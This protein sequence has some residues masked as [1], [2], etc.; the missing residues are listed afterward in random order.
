MEFDLAP[1]WIHL[2]TFYLVS[3]PR[4]VRE[5]VERYRRALDANPL[6]IEELFDSAHADDNLATRSKVALAAYL[7]GRRE[8]IALTP[9]TTTGLALLYNGLRIRPDQEILTTEH[10]HYVHHES[11]RYAAER[12]G[13]AVRF[14]AL[15]DFPAGAARASVA[16]MVE[17]L[18]R[19]ISPKTRA[20]GLTWVHSATGLKLPIP[21]LAEVVARANSG[22]ADAD[23]CLLIV[24]GVH[25]F[26]VENVDA[27][28]LGADF[29]VASAHKWLFAPRGTGLIWGRE[30]AW[31]E[32][33]PTIPNFDP[34]GGR[35]FD[36]WLE[37]SA[38]PPTRAA[39]VS[40]GGFTAYEHQ[41][42]IA[43]ALEFHRLLGRSRITSR[44][45]KL[46][47]RIR[48]GAREDA[49]RHPAH[50]GRE[51]PLRR[52]RL[53]RGRGTHAGR[54]RRE[55]RR[56][57]DSRHH[58]AVQAL[59]R[60]ARGR[61]HEPGR[62]DRHRDR[63]GARSHPGLSRLLAAG[64]LEDAAG[65]RFEVLDVDGAVLLEL[66]LGRGEHL[67]AAAV[68]DPR[69]VHG[70][71][72]QGVGVVLGASAPG[73]L[74]E[75]DRA[76]DEQDEAPRAELL[77]LEDMSR[78]DR[79]GEAGADLEAPDL[80]LAHRGLERARTLRLEDLHET[81]GLLPRGELVD[82][83][84]DALRAGARKAAGVGH[85]VARID[86]PRLDSARQS[87]G[88]QGG[89][90]GGDFRAVFHLE[91]SL[92]GDLLHGGLNGAAATPVPGSSQRKTGRPG[93][94]SASDSSAGAW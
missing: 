67:A 17:R 85:E 70:E 22:R 53:F 82:D 57:P 76:R 14:V 32:I 12:S 61:D 80:E 43:D 35:A 37:R 73:V 38:L 89:S 81:L 11:I 19:A 74:A 62:G 1:D 20:V 15:H 64:D 63:R 77:V 36:A 27:A 56:A 79:I 7:G 86:L 25:G 31:A 23:R 65:L 13:A 6:S 52:H 10:D 46:N 84:L 75:G 88:K 8:E 41:F 47:S 4:M 40:P 21:E 93:A 91:I 60:A 94:G 66:D 59:L 16:E 58:D 49:R 44:I 51:Q 55:T 28:Q 72:D 83:D 54:R 2:G 30:E 92:A 48:R 5:A 26:G 42:A 34:D 39:F 71:L 9:N 69:A 33:R 50:A 87:Q 78:R 45:H 3:H 90:G 68:V 24:D 18:R 29:F